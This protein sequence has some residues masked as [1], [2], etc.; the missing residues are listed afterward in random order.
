MKT[1]RYPLFFIFLLCGQIKTIDKQQGKA[2]NRTEI[3]ESVLHNFAKTI[4]PKETTE[5]YRY[6]YKNTDGSVK[7]YKYTYNNYKSK[8]FTNNF[9]KIRSQAIKLMVRQSCAFITFST[10]GSIFLLLTSSPNDLTEA[11][12]RSIIV[13]CTTYVRCY[14]NDLHHNTFTVKKIKETQF[15]N[16]RN[17]NKESCCNQ[18]DFFRDST[19]QLISNFSKNRAS[20][21]F[22]SLLSSILYFTSFSHPSNNN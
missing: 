7:G 5:D 10:I 4:N 16:Q 2:L 20:N 17:N 12:L 9:E 1:T 18:I 11:S 13:G 22:L 8:C 6:F 15:L 3:K 21:F 14:G 19:S